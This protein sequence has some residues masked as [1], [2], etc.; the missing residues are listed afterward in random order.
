MTSLLFATALAGL[1]ALT[2]LHLRPTGVRAATAVPS[3]Q[4]LRGPTPRRRRAL[5]L[6]EPLAWA[7]R[8]AALLCALGGT[9]ASRAGC[10]AD[11]RPVAVVDAAS[12]QA[13]AE[14][15]ALAPTRAGFLGQTPVVEGEGAG[16][17]LS[18]LRACSDTRPACLLRA[19]DRSGRPLLLLGAVA[20]G[21]WRLA[22][23]HRG[24]AFSFLRTGAEAPPPPAEKVAPVAVAEVQLRG[25]SSA[26]RLW[27]AALAA[28]ASPPSPSPSA[29]PRGLPEVIVVD[30]RARAEPAA[31]TVLSV[32]GAGPAQPEAPAVRSQPRTGLLFPDP[33]DVAARTAGLGLVAS[34]AFEEDARFLPVLGLAARSKSSPQ[35]ALAATGEELA[36]W[37]HQGNLLPLARAL[38]ASGLP[39]PVEAEAAPAGGGL[40][41]TDGE[42]RAAPVGLLDVSP[43]RYLRADGRVALQLLRTEV[44]GADAL[45][46]KGLASLGGQPWRAKGAA[47]VHLPTVLFSLALALWLSA[48]FLTRGV[49]RAWLPAAAVALALALLV[50][51]VRW[52]GVATAPWTAVLEVPSGPPA[53]AL[54]ALARQ[55]SVTPLQGADAAALACAGPL[56]EAPCTPLATVGWA[57]TPGR[58][59]DAL[60]FD[61]EKPRV[62]VLSVEAPKEVALGTAAEVWVTLRVRRAQGRHLTLAAHSTSLAPASVD[63]AVEGLDVVRTLRLVLSP[64]QQGVVFV[65]VE[66]RVE[67]EPQA[68]DGRLLA[69]AVRLRPEKRLVLAAAPSWEARAAASA[70][71]THDARVDVLNRLGTRAVVAKGQPAQAP[72]DVLTER[73]AL[74]GVGLL[75]LVGFGPRELDAAASAGL[76]H[77]VESGGAALLLDAPGAAEALGLEVPAVPGAAPLQPLQGQLASLGVLSFQGYAPPASF[78]T[79]AGMAVLGRLGP[80]GQTEAL[81]WVVGRALGQGRVAVVTAPDVWRLSPPGEGRAAYQHVL[82]HLA[83]W[84]EAPAASRRGAV[85]SEDWASLRLEEGPGAAHV[86]PLPSAET[87]D[88]LPLDGPDVAT[89]NRSPRA[90]LRARAAAVHHPFLELEGTEAL[91]A[92]WGR[93]PP[94]PQLAR[95]VRARASAG[96]FALLAALLVLEALAR[97]R[98]GASGGSGRRASSAAS[99]EDTGGITSGEG[100]N[101]RA[102]ETPASRAALRNA[103]PS[104][105]A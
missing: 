92:A 31:L 36:G 68:E 51:D 70:L 53:R 24:R 95:D 3:L 26:A 37:A 100:T 19:A 20:G 25:T 105:P 9:C 44:L 35:L 13:W 48:V 103:A 82:A 99:S 61:V 73:K 74:E 49:R 14:A 22:L 6:E 43:G 18:V 57:S 54:S 16:L 39:G 87:L 62:D 38:L 83:G 5:P 63:M 2:W 12:S 42:G 97:R 10:A 55:A 65:A 72:R 78:Q 7:L 94:S 76:R 50:A 28:A 81:P 75:T 15:R 52:A 66:A 58:A 69:M 17:L 86:L 11:V 56:A 27:A 60:L 71:E 32:D 23:A 4:H 89:L 41:W 21:E 98:Y 90:A 93:L 47:G 85:L 84:L 29:A 79:P 45:D 102:K 91:A 1:L 104:V 33:L 101:Q 46:E 96:A 34:L 88:G 67:G 30:A 80:A 77:Y 8:A 40:G 59:V 64:L